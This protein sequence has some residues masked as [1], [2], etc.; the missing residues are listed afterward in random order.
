MTKLEVLFLNGNKLQT[1]PREISKLVNLTV[2]DVGSN[3]LK[4]NISN[5]EYDWNW[6]VFCFRDAQVAFTHV[7]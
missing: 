5:W 4:Y 7:V 2:M 1:L 3:V 6:Y